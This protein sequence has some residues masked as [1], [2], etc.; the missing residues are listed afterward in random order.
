MRRTDCL[1]VIV[2]MGNHAN[3]RQRLVDDEIGQDTTACSCSEGA[4]A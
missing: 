3:A 2:M 4:G 1:K